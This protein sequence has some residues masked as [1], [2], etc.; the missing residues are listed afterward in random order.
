MAAY[1]Y[2]I[3]D[4]FDRHA[5]DRQST[6]RLHGRARAQRQHDARAG[7]GDRVQRDRLRASCRG[8]RKRPDPHLY[9]DSTSFRSPVTRPWAQPSSSARRSLAVIGLEPAVARSCRARAGRV[10][11]IVFGWMTQPVPAIEPYDDVAPLFAALGGRGLRAPVELYD[12]GATHVFVALPSEDAVAAMR[13]DVA[14]LAPLEVTGVNCFA[15]SGDRWKLR[16]FWPRGR[17][18][19][20]ARR[21]GRS[22]ATSRVTAASP[23]E[24]RS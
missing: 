14:A 9:A 8:G 13:P 2:V 17:T 15:G 12:N 4:V 22:P 10:G 23:G 3:A 18:P 20:R 16:M 7:A 21:P 5:A 19:P 6:R 24:P 11:R 1:R